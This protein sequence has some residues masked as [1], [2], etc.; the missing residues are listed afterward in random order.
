MRPTVLP[1][2]I[3][4]LTAAPASAQV[5]RWVDDQGTVN[6]ANKPPTDGRQATRID[7]REPRVSIIPLRELRVSRTP[8]MTLAPAPVGFP[9]NVDRLTVSNVQ[10]G[11]EWRERCF[12][13]RRVD[14]TNPTGATYDFGTTYA[15]GAPF[16]PALR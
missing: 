1:L 8:P 11:L 16:A 3:L 10:T 12:A 2:L 7:A 15:P 6:Y 5:Y 4:A 9:G 13:E 14:C